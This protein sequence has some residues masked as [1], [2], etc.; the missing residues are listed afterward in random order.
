MAAQKRDYYD[1]LGVSREASHTEI[2]SAYRKLAR[3][4]HPDVS[5]DP[6]A[7]ERFQELGEA[8]AVLSDGD[9]RAHYDRFGHSGP[10]GVGFDGGMPDFFEIFQ[11]VVGGFGFERDVARGGSDLSYELPVTLED[12][13]TGVSSEVAVSRMVVCEA[14]GGEGAAPVATTPLPT[15][16]R[17]MAA[18]TTWRPESSANMVGSGSMAAILSAAMPPTRPPNVPPAAICPIRRRAVAPVTAAR[19]LRPVK[20]DP[21]VIAWQDHQLHVRH[22]DPRIGP[23]SRQGARI[24]SAVQLASDVKGLRRR[25]GDTRPARSVASPRTGP[26]AVIGKAGPTSPL[27]ARER[28]P[29]AR[30]R[31]LS[32]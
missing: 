26:T 18:Q 24:R 14:C 10:Q 29:S 13:A 32:R 3:K 12:V 7:H 27:H 2:R 25:R 31:R 20:P 15:N 30:S 5:E 8:Y 16:R 21:L 1:V 28:G 19:Y 23:Y 11:S 6:N 4:Y 17:A 9:R 22:D